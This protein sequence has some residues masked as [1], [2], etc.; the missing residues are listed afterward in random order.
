MLVPRMALTRGAPATVAGNPRSPPHLLSL[1]RLV[2]TLDA[3][4]KPYLNPHRPF[5]NVPTRC[6]RV[7]LIGALVVVA[8]SARPLSVNAQEAD[9]TV[10]PIGYF[11]G[12]SMGQGMSQNGFRLG[13][14]DL[15]AM[16][17]GFADGLAKKEPQLSD[18]QLQATQGK[19]SFSLRIDELLP[20]VIPGILISAL[21]GD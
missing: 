15:D 20:R 4:V 18:V 16:K 1:C 12:I 3:R 11:L 14:F 17:A 9:A 6:F 13:D 19:M 7:S 21:E 2:V 10:D 5:Y 8:L